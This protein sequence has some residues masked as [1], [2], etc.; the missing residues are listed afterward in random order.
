MSSFSHKK[1]LKFII[2]LGTGTFGSNGNDQVTLL[3]YRASVDIDKA[4]G[5]QMSMLRAKIYGVKQDDMN[6]ITTLMW[7][8]LQAIKNTVVV[9][10][11]D[12]EVETLVFRG[13][14]VESWGNYQSIPDVFLYI[15]AQSVFYEQLAPANPLSFNGPVSVQTVMQKIA[16]GMGLIFENNGVSTVLNDC[17]LANTLTEQAKDVVRAAGCSMYIDDDTLA[18]T[19]QYEPRAGQ[20]PDISAESGLVGYPSFDG[21]GV[22]FETLFNPAIVFGGAVRLRTSIIQAAGQWVVTSLSHH[23]M[24]ETPNGAWFT[25]VRGT[26]GNLAITR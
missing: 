23:L 16:T 1:Q 18:I 12:G 24:S 17:Y 9:Y 4:G 22:M 14:I 25:S 3:G 26:L 21:T 7:K 11:V 20:I 15:K 6:A 19:N 10:A 13:N 8:P 2:T 5:I